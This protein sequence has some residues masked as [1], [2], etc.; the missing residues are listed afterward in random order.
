VIAI[1]SRGKKSTKHILRIK[2]SRTMC[3]RTPEGRGELIRSK[4]EARKIVTCLSCLSLMDKQF[5]FRI[6]R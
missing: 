3:G 1:Q 5:Q 6:K 4:D 2:G